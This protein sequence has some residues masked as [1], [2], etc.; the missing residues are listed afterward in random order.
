MADLVAA[1][2]LF[3]GLVFGLR[4]GFYKEL[5]AFGSLVVAAFMARML[6]RPVGDM[7][8]ARTGLGA[9]V[10]EVA[11][12][13]GIFLVVALILN[14]IGRT[15]LNKLKNPDGENALEEGADSIADAIQDKGKKG[16][17]T[18]LTDPIAKATSGVVYW[19]DKLLGAVLGVAKS[20]VAV[21]LIFVLVT[22]WARWTGQENA[23]TTSIRDSFVAKGF[24]EVV[25]PHLLE[26]DEYRFLRNIDRVERLADEAK[27]DPGKAKQIADHPAVQPMRIHP[28]VVALG[29]DPS[30]A[31]AWKRGDVKG[32]LL[33]KNVRELLAD[34]SF[35]DAFADADL[36]KVL[37]DLVRASSPNPAPEPKPDPATPP[38]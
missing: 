29:N 25:E 20:V 32:L 12:A 6:R 19:T 34:P 35:R 2:F 33:N 15:I 7:I 16:P 8:G 17:M 36:D 18:L 23:F 28:R 9:T 14:I 30:V 22:Y 11:A 3:Y 1:I 21:A 26:T 24:H 5:I 38:K 37:K 27:G 10:G 13:M 4:R 31:D